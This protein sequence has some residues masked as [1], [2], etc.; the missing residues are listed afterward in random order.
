MSVFWV[1]APCSLVGATTQMTAIFVLTAVRTSNPTQHAHTK[2]QLRNIEREPSNHVS[3]ALLFQWKEFVVGGTWYKSPG[4]Y[5]A[6]W[7]KRKSHTAGECTVLWVMIG[8][9]AWRHERSYGPVGRIP[10]V[11]GAPRFTV[12]LAQVPDYVIMVTKGFDQKSTNVRFVGYPKLK[13]TVVPAPGHYGS[14]SFRS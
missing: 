3:W 2:R 9:T 10:R 5:S 11:A 6:V 7:G 1:V 8:Y 13:S 14:W 4:N 12:K